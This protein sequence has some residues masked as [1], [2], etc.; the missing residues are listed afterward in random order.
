MLGANNHPF[1][2]ADP[3]WFRSFQVYLHGHIRVKIVFGISRL[4]LIPMLQYVAQIT[5]LLD[6]YFREDLRSL[7]EL[8]LPQESQYV[9]KVY[10][11]SVDSFS[12]PFS[13]M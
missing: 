11:G 2:E 13:S 1:L 9:L 8:N 3:T 4:F 7:V 6:F 12:F 5:S 10:L